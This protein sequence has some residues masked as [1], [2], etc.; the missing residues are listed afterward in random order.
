MEKRAM[1]GEGACL[2]SNRP[3]VVVSCAPRVQFLES[4][5]STA[6]ATPWISPL[7]TTR[8]TA[9]QRAQRSTR[10]HQKR[11]SNGGSGTDQYSRISRPAT[12][13]LGSR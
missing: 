12:V 6:L 7:V 10:T 8:L 3:G 11:C 2:Y 1:N 13:P 5:I 9:R 4:N